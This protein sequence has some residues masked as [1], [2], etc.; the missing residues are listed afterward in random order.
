MSPKSGRIFERSLIESYISQH[1]SDPILTDTPLSVDELISIKT[2]SP[3]VPPRPP[4]LTSVPSLLASLQTQWDALALETFTLR[5]Q[6]AKTRQELSTALYYH[7]SAISVVARLTKERDEARESLARLAASIGTQPQ[8]PANNSSATDIPTSSNTSF[9][10][11]PT[12]ISEIKD[13]QK[14]LTKMRR[15]REPADNWATLSDLTALHPKKAS[16]QH[17]QHVKDFSLGPQDMLLKPETT[18]DALFLLSGG[19]SSKA[20]IFN[21]LAYTKNVL[22]STKTG[23]VT[24]SSWIS[25]KEEGDNSPFVLGTNSN[26]IE[27]YAM[28]SKGGKTNA[29]PGT[30]SDEPLSIIDISQELQSSKENHISLIKRHP[31]S[32]LVVSLSTGPSQS[33]WSLLDITDLSAP[34]VLGSVASE[35]GL[36]FSTLDIH[37]DGH[38]VAVGTSDGT[39]QVY[40]IE[41][42]DK[43]AELKLPGASSNNA[44]SALTFCENGYWLAAAYHH[45]KDDE[46]DVDGLPDL[47]GTALIW[48]IRK[49]KITFTIPFGPIK[50]TSAAAGTKSKKQPNTTVISKLEFDLSGKHL[51]AIAGTVVA[52]VSYVKSSKLWTSG[53][54]SA[55]SSQD[56]DEQ[57]VAN[58]GSLFS[59]TTTHPI[60]DVAWGPL[61]KSLYIVT[62]KGSFQ[63]FSSK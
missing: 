40:S 22:F 46:M 12:I 4:T 6:L 13:T 44:V 63:E 43:I 5:Q 17:F 62:D 26:S 58:G 56:L 23:A 3:I 48:D 28:Q 32:G 50:D 10:L 37:P 7:D 47:V 16:K 51:A 57:V 54:V 38:L 34:K 52:V 33:V 19:S 45:N 8:A 49:L 36:H 20:G 18:D 21:T 15:Q 9:E 53:L 31:V 30:V 11:P 24:S 1:G 55:G 42:A 2:D 60:V 14:Q 41:T 25:S 39:I 61:A 59:S 35:E 29:E 27:V